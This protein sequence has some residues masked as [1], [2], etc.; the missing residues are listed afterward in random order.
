MIAQL[1]HA[2]DVAAL[3]YRQQGTKESP[4]KEQGSLDHE[5]WRKDEHK[6][7]NHRRSSSRPVLEQAFGFHGPS[8]GGGTSTLSGCRLA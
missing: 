5:R 2:R 8:T 7:Q 6:P 3:N 1:S 4:T